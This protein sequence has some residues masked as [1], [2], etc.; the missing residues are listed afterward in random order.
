MGHPAGRW[1]AGAL[2]INPA[3]QPG[4]AARRVRCCYRVGLATQGPSSSSVIQQ[5]ILNLML[6]NLHRNTEVIRD[7]FKIFFRKRGY[8]EKLIASMLP[9]TAATAASGVS[10]M[11]PSELIIPIRAVL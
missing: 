1:L 9:E 4:A 3:C 8:I 7:L 2:R 11:R 5:L 10:S 6:D